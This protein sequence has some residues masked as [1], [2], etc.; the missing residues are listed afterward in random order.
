[1]KRFV[2]A[3]RSAISDKNY[4]AALALA[5][6]LPDIASKLENPAVQG[7]TRY[8]DWCR[9]YLEPKYY[10]PDFGPTRDEWWWLSAADTYALRCALLHEGG[11]DISQ[12]RAR[13]TLDRIIFV[14][15]TEDV[16]RHR[17]RTGT[18]VM[19]KVDVFCEDVC[20]GVE[21]WLADIAGDPAIEARMNELILIRDPRKIISF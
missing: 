19:L 4:Y 8:K 13:E 10:D 17:V 3:V 20:V 7:S 14:L 21:Q 2:D 11:D 9:K 12:Q 1:M 15:P 16:G 18:R 6:T 5:L